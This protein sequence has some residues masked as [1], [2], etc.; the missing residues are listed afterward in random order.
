MFCVAYFAGSDLEIITSQSYFL[1]KF[2][3]NYVIAAKFSVIIK[4]SIIIVFTKHEL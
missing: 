4:T 3:L 2:T 1:N